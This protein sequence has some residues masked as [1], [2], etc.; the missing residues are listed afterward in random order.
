MKISS[1]Q[2][3]PTNYYSQTKQV[4]PR[5]SEPQYA[6]SVSFKGHTQYELFY[7]DGIDLL[8]HQTAFFR[9]AKTN[10]TACDYIRETFGKKK[11]IKIVSG[12]CSTGEEALSLSMMLKDL[13]KR[14]RIQGIDLGERAIAQAKEGRYVIASPKKGQSLCDYYRTVDS[15]PYSDFYISAQGRELS[16]Q[17]Q[18]YKELF[19]EHM[20][21]TGRD[22]PTPFTERVRNLFIR[23][24]GE[25]PLLLQRTEYKVKE[26]AIKNCRFTLGNIFDLNE[27]TKGEKSDAIFFKNAMYHLT[28]T[29]SD[30]GRRIV[31][32]DSKDVITRLIKTFKKNLNKNGLVVFGE[33][34]E[35][36][37]LDMKTLPVVMKELGFEQLKRNGKVYENIWKLGQ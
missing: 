3:Y 2:N 11:S 31:R 24:V 29:S 7:K 12:G 28:T 1:I 17:E 20:E 33:N 22:V 30:D 26:G 19:L 36:Q 32:Y 25:T 5:L 13:K 14:V 15:S 16:K 34:E 23:M 21:P 18:K 8:I 4:R 27:L 10:E 35:Q 6:D 37:M 9:D